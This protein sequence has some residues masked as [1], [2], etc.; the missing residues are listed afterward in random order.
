L[1]IVRIID[2]LQ[3]LLQQFITQFAISRRFD[4]QRVSNNKGASKRQV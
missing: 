2:S 4:R 1:V 3:L